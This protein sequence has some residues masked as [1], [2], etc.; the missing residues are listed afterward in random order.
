M[1]S[2]NIGPIDHVDSGKTKQKEAAADDDIEATNQ[3][4]E[5]EG[6]CG[7]IQSENTKGSDLI[8]ENTPTNHAENIAQIFKERC[9]LAKKE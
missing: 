9:R 7:P 2:A 8:K 1:T 5:A 6:K 3:I 4:E